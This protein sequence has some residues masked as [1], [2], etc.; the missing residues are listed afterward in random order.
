MRE[1]IEI[2]LSSERSANET[3]IYQADASRVLGELRVYAT[4]LR[5]AAQMAIDIGI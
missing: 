4:S 5:Q 1:S 2:F 3:I